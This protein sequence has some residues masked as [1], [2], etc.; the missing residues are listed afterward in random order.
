MHGSLDTYRGTSL[1]INTHMGEKADRGLHGPRGLLHPHAC[2]VIE[3]SL[4]TSKIRWPN[5]S[6][7]PARTVSV[8][9]VVDTWLSLDTYWYD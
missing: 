3:F 5:V 6:L 7:G 4:Q 9:V 1:I 8:V 2:H